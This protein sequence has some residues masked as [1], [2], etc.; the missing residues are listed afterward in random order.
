M[1]QTLEAE[2]KAALT[3]ARA[4]SPLEILSAVA[5]NPATD[6][7]KIEKL[8]GLV[9]RWE[10]RQAEKAYG[11]ALAKFQGLCPTVFKRRQAGDDDPNRKGGLKYTFASFD[12]VMR[13]AS[14][15]LAE[16]G[17]SVT[18]DTEHTVTGEGDAK[19]GTITIKC[20]VRVGGHFEDH[21]FTAPVPA[22]LRVSDTQVYGAGLSYLKRY[23]L[24]AA[25]N[26]V[27]TD[28]DTDAAGLMEYL[29]AEQV[30]E[31][32]RLIAER[33]AR[34]NTDLKEA[35]AAFLRLAQAE[36]LSRIIR[37]DFTKWADALRRKARAS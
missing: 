16:C 27:V 35:T 12:D 5:A 34:S 29:T 22:G 26:I 20:R 1:T 36:S 17:I 4:P 32:E 3:P 23:A 24:C 13:E 11:D 25:L 15:I 2:P 6:P 7:D 28:E 30:K 21:K 31:L 9:E 10:A 18:F 8:M 19:L 37:R 14:P 33:A